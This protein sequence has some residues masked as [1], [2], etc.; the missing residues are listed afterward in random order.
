MKAFRYYLLDRKGNLVPPIVGKVDN[1][2]GK[3]GNIPLLNTNDASDIPGI[4]NTAKHNGTS[5]IIAPDNKYSVR[6]IGKEINNMLGYVVNADRDKNAREKFDYANKLV[7]NR[8]DWDELKNFFE[9]YRDGMFNGDKLKTLDYLDSGF[10]SPVYNAVKSAVDRN[11]GYKGIDKEHLSGSRYDDKY[12]SRN[13]SHAAYVDD[14][15]KSSEKDYRQL[16]GALGSTHDTLSYAYGPDRIALYQVEFDPDDIYTGRDYLENKETAQVDYPAEGKVKVNKVYPG[17][18]IDFDRLMAKKDETRKAARSSEELN[19]NF[20]N[21]LEPVLYTKP[22]ELPSDERL[23]VIKHH[24][25][26][27]NTQRMIPAVQRGML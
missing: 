18:R 13:L 2:E 20:K 1:S 12:D 22:E 25:N 3:Y 14:S 11:I 6:N 8:Y 17:M 10:N 5:V 9:S 16:M 24:N 4:F 15:G 23:K 19:N 27:V 21:L 7:G 26:W